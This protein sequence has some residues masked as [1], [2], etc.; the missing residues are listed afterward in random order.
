[1]F[2]LFIIIL[3]FLYRNESKEFLFPQKSKHRFSR[4]FKSVFACIIYL[5]IILLDVEMTMHL[6]LQNDV[7]RQLGFNYATPEENEGEIFLIT[8]IESGNVMDRSGLKAG[9]QVSLDNVDD[10]YRLLVYN[11]NK[12]VPIPVRRG[13]ESIVVRPYV[14]RLKL[15]IP[16][17]WI[18]WI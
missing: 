4:I 10:L 12:T 5:G 15:T 6:I 14:P 3:N 17:E 8:E 7:N 16:A 1:M 9:D 2:S 13:R 11:Q 18:W